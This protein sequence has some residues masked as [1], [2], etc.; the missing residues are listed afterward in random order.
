MSSANAVSSIFPDT[1]VI[2]A[3]ITAVVA[4][5]GVFWQLR[6]QFKDRKM[7]ATSAVAAELAHIS[8]HYIHSSDLLVFD[9]PEYPMSR[10]LRLSKYGPTLC[11]KNL[12][13]FSVLGAQE[14][15]EYLQMS[16]VCRNNDLI[17]DEY[18]ASGRDITQQEI[19][20]LRSRMNAVSKTADHLL[21]CIKDQD[22]A[23]KPVHLDSFFNVK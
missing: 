2:A 5:I 19:E 12:I 17:L 13:D 16:F 4:L 14:M 21:A 9:G 20:F 7:A 10:R 11:S 1:T 15:A 22:L 23:R 6:M 3:A 18:L 8:S